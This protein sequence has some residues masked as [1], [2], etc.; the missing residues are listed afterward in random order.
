[1]TIRRNIRL[2]VPTAF[3]GLVQRSGI[4]EVKAVLIG[5]QREAPYGIIHSQERDKGSSTFLEMRQTTVYYYDNVAAFLR[6][7]LSYRS[8]CKR[9]EPGM[10]TAYF[11]SNKIIVFH[12]F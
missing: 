8:M 7:S 12:G 6:K 3:T 1:M 11:N 5:C 9:G 10:N 2:F 4:E